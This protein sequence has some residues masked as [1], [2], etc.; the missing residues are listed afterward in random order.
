MSSPRN[1]IES[2]IEQIEKWNESDFSMD[3]K[4][5]TTILEA[6]MKEIKENITKGIICFLFSLFHF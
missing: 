2:K 4:E 3:T 6:K 5:K 1:L